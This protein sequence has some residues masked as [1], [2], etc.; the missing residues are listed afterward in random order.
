MRRSEGAFVVEGVKLLASALAAGA[1]VEAV[2]VD[3]R[4]RSHAELGAVLDAATSGGARV[5]DLA[6]GVLER[7]ADTVTPQPVLAVVGMPTASLDQLRAATFVVVCV[8]VRDPGNAGAVIRVAHAAGAHAVVCCEG[9]VDP[10]NP[11]TVRASAGSLLHIPVVVAGDAAEVLDTLSG[12]G[13]R[14]LAAVSSGGTSYTAVD[15]VAPLALVLGNEANGLPARL[16]DRLEALVTIPM[17]GGAESLNVST[18]AAV[19]CFETARRRS[20]LHAMEDVR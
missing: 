13:L 10:F 15:L 6:P 4:A 12:H 9:T 11:K 3:D 1:P 20:N 8:D 16:E 7:V 5:F 18:A 19:L 17:G 14:R 2:F